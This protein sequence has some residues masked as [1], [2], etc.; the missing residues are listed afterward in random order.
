MGAAAAVLPVG[1]WRDG[2]RV[3]EAV[4]RPMTGA[5][6]EFLLESHGGMSS[7]HRTSALLGRCVQRIGSEQPVTPELAG[8]LAIGD[9]E[10]LLLLLRQITFGDR[11][12][13]VVSCPAQGCGKPMDVPLRVSELLTAPDLAVPEY[14]ERHEIR[15]RLPAG[16]DQ[17][18]VAEL[19]RRDPQAA[20]DELLRRCIE[21]NNGLAPAVVQSIAAEMAELDP[22]AE[23][24]LSLQCPEC[25]HTFTSLFDAAAFLFEEAAMRSRELYREV[26]L[27]AFHYHWSEEEILSLSAQ[28]RRRYLD[29]LLEALG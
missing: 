17:E 27:L 13:P 14:M 24:R 23:I 21:S 28:K 10:A 19:A 5:D 9:R 8:E 6:Q 11:L 16:K 29:L 26:H 15:F 3:K 12:D 18:A 22:Q 7:A 25:G 4:L 1:L 20:G 2:A